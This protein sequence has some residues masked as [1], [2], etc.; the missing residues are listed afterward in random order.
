MPL[1][2]DVREG[3]IRPRN[4]LQTD[5]NA[6]KKHNQRQRE[7]AEPDLRRQ[8]IA[9][10]AAWSEAKRHGASPAPNVQGLHA[11]PIAAAIRGRAPRPRHCMH[12]AFPSNPVHSCVGN[13]TLIYHVCTCVHAQGT[14]S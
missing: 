12:G 3:A 6:K 11:G 1:Q 5:R 8:K 7:H 14:R 10:L 9:T 4:A 13:T 2:D